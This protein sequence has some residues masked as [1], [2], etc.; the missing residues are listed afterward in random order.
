AERDGEREDAD[1][2][3]AKRHLRRPTHRPP[4]LVER[5]RARDNRD[6]RKRNREVRE[7][8]DGAEQLLRVAER[9]QLADV[10]EALLLVHTAHYSAPDASLR[11]RIELDRAEHVAFGVLK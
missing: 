11:A 6:D 3:P 5:D 4:V 10:V 7:A 1:Q 2:R 9:A 8:A